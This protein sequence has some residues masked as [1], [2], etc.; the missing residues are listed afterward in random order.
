MSSVYK[1]GPFYWAD[2]LHLI[3]ELAR[4]LVFI[5]FGVGAQK[6]PIFLGSAFR[7]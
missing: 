4:V 6:K 5:R 7:K 3:L 2:G 1:G